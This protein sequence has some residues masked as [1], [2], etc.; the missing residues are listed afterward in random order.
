MS[1]NS[2]Q[3]RDVKY[4]KER[5]DQTNCHCQPFLISYEFRTSIPNLMGIYKEYGKAEAWSITL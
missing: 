1:S 5:L 2:I 3:A 4:K